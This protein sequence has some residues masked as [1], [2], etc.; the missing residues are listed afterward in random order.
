MDEEEDEEWEK[1]YGGYI[2]K[3]TLTMENEE[4]PDPEPGVLCTK[5]A[6]P[7]IVAF[8]NH[9]REYAVLKY[10]QYDIKKT[11]KHI[12]YAVCKF[13]HINNCE[14]NVGARELPNCKTVTFRSCNLEQKCK[15][16]G[17]D[18]NPKCNSRFVADYLLRTM[19]SSISLKKGRKI[20]K[21]IIWLQLK[22]D[23]SYWVTNDARNMV[24]GKLNST[25]EESLTKVPQ[26][27]TAATTLN[28]ESI[29][30]FTYAKDGELDRFENLF[31]SYIAQLKGFS[32]G[33][34]LV[35]WLD[36]MHL[37]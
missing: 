10:M 28:P 29:G 6:F 21:K 12:C 9:L 22:V 20:K 36:A 7:D 3:Q 8:R 4:A 26:L 5:M 18:T 16:T 11:D 35:I 23:I 19:S 27:C 25:F 30:H 17:G 2:G 14:W 24:L 32:N 13:R 31:I 1:D 34:R 15:R 37:T 33:C